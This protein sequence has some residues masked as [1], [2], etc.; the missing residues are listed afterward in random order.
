MLNNIRIDTSSEI[1]SLKFAEKQ[2]SARD[3]KVER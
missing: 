2:I 3:L 1:I